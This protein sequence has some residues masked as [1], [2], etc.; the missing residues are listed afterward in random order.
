MRRCVL[1]RASACVSLT[2][3][4]HSLVTRPPQHQLELNAD[5]THFALTKPSEYRRDQIGAGMATPPRLTLNIFKAPR[6]EPGEDYRMLLRL[7]VIEAIFVVLLC[8][9]GLFWECVL[10]I[11]LCM[12][13]LLYFVCLPVSS[14]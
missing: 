11:P 8:L 3:I 10:W 7:Q 2:E 1:I 9:L 14:W 6:G 12:L 5:C 13:P 4:G